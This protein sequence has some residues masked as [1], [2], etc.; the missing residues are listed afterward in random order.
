MLQAVG[1]ISEYNPFHNGHLYQLKQAKSRTGAD[2]AIAV[3]SGNWL[4]RGEPALYDKWARAQAALESGVDVVIELPFYSAVQPSHIFSAGAVRLI[5][6]MN[7]HWLAFG[8]E[9]PGVDYQTLIENQPRKDNSFKQFDRPYASIFQEYLYQKTGIRLDQ[10]NDILAF[11]Y[12]NANAD[13][14]YPLT[15]V[16]IK[17]VGSNHNDKQLTT[18]VISSASAIRN[19]LKKDRVQLA[20]KFVP[21]ASQHLINTDSMITWEQFWPLLRFELIEAPI[22]QLQKIYQMTEGIEY[23]LKQ[24]AIEAKTFPEFLHLVKTKRYT[25]TRIQR[26]CCYVLLHATA[27]EMLLNPQ[28]I[29]L[30]GCTGLG[31]RYLNQIKRSLKLPMISKVNQET[32]AT[33][34]GLDFKAGMLTEMTNGRHQDFYKHPIILEN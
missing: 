31:R 13:L 1:I 29:R 9:T 10:P 24:A 8:V 16:P 17:R 32:V 30:L 5:S 34:V 15:L 23:R 21:K 2:V 11:G 33:L 20:E 28:Y 7:C 18:G 22:G 27:A 6:A 25:Y 14:G 19:S 26:L 3:M 12:A 4:Q